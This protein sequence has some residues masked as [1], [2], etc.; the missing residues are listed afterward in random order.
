MEKSLQELKK[1]IAL[2]TEELLARKVTVFVSSNFITLSGNWTWDLY[3]D[4]IFCSDV[5]ITLPEEFIGARALIHPEDVQS[6]KEILSGAVR[7]NLQLDFRIITSFGEVKRIRGERI[8]I[9][10]DGLQLEDLQ[11]RT[12][13]LANNQ[14]AMQKDYEHL[15]LVRE[16]YERTEKYTGIGLWFYNA[17]HNETWYSPEVFRIYGLPPHSLNAHLNTFNQFIHPEDKEQVEEYIDKAFRQKFPLHLEFRIRTATEEKYVQYISGWF[18]NNRGEW[19]HSGTIQDISS[20][21]KTEQRIEHAENSV[22]F[23]RQQIVFDEDMARLGHWQMNLVTR[24]T[25]YTD[26]IYRI[27]GL[28]SSS[29]LT[30]LN[31]F[32]NYVHPDDREE[33]IQSN[34]K[35]LNEHRPPDMEYRIIRSDGKLR[36]LRQKGKLLNFGGELIMACTM[37]DVTVLRQLEKKREEEAS[38]EAIRNFILQQTEE[39]SNTGSWIWDLK[40]GSI[41]W[42]ES[43][44]R[45]LGL[46]PNTIELSQKVLL[47]YIHPEDQKKFSDE[48]AL[49]LHNRTES[50]FNFR[51]LIRGQVRQMRALFRILTS[52]TME[53]F[54]ATIQDITQEFNLQ[55]DLNQKVQMAEGLSEN[56][57]DRLLIT[58][59]NNTVIFWNRR[60]EEVYGIPKEE[61]LGKNFFDV[62]PHLKTDEELQ[63]FYQ[64]L[65]G[66]KLT[67]LASRSSLLLGYFDLHM[68]PL[69]NADHAEVEGIIHI[70]H[71]VTKEVELRQNLNDRLSFIENMVESSVDRIIAMDRNMN[72]LVW[73]KKCEEYYGLKKEQV[74]GK[75]VLEIFPSGT[76]MPG[77]EDFR[78]VLRGEQVYIPADATRNNFNEIFLIPVKSAG[79]EITAVLWMEHSLSQTY[80]LQ[81]SEHLLRKTIEASPDAITIYDL[82]LR[83]P[84]YINDTLAEWIGV[85]TQE[86]L[87][88]G[89]EGRLELIH[90]DDRDILLESNKKLL[91]S[92]DGELNT[93]EYRIRN[94]AGKTIW[95]N[96][97][98]KVFKRN[99]Q[100]KVVQIL[101]LLQDITEAIELRNQLAE[102]S[103]YAE[104]IIDSSVDRILVCDLDYKVTAWN[105]RS[106]EVLGIGK[107]TVIGKDLREMFPKI[108]DKKEFRE[109][110]EAAARGEFVRQEP[111]QSIY[112]TGIYER[113]YLP[114]KNNDGSV[115]AMVCIMHEVTENFNQREELIQLNKTL[116][117]KNRELEQKNDEISNFAFVASHDLK[118]PLRKIHTFSDW[119]MQKETAN[120][121]PSA[122]N[123][124]QK[125]NISVKRM[126]Q[127]IEDILVLTKIH[128]GGKKQ[129]VVDL[130]QVLRQVKNEMEE[131]ISSTKAVIEADHLPVVQGSENQ[132][133]HLF[134]NVISN[135]IK[136]Q[137][138]GNVPR[139]EI[140]AEQVTGNSA[141]LKEGID[142]I[143]LSFTDNGFGFD[144][145]YEKKIF[146]V[147]QRLHGKSEYEGTGIGLAICKKIMENHGGTIRVTS[148]EGKGST[149]C[150]FFP[151]S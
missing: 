121:S 11:Q 8:S 102:R 33:V 45:I 119:L 18:F 132:L 49:M 95:V 14:L 76:H 131:V 88:M 58:D 142:Y 50:E 25:T 84:Y 125:I 126:E 117:Q 60:C 118:E 105:R 146:Q 74:I 61:A 72:Y 100:G 10:E 77:Y 93:I 1:K 43:F 137:E 115:Y 150:C 90:P 20:Q 26:Q 62:F 139:I 99:E 86:L 52:A 12:V 140:R 149:F 22:S 27:H 134:H 6:V 91:T 113:Y 110:F 97:R 39:M 23:F 80:Q 107:E 130:N 4:T 104:E 31:A 83:H 55:Q 21:K 144:K 147:F 79:G 101:S 138:D 15:L 112:T 70:V 141:F 145:K 151:L 36:Y 57:L 135:A 42:N 120:L 56:I 35:M 9:E 129:E 38:S 48:L 53:L 81:E 19:I 73:N 148:E 51:F 40:T 111:M 82:E 94:T 63:L 136:F 29:S 2:G 98:S 114:L 34:K 67:R 46:K 59:I 75:N 17:S 44:Y 103:R 24:K 71:D 66:E 28:K 13:E 124:L 143:K 127:L 122:H 3:S 47:F 41:S 65:K 87:D 32:L 108:W 128:S 85:S 89:Y 5:M 133:Y 106:E 123:Y 7:K 109:G 68:L 37:Q 116:E 92:G 30:G 54:V 69:W 78:K 64:V 16:L 96:N